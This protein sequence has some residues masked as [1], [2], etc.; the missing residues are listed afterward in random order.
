[1]RLEIDKPAMKIIENS[2][3]T[4]IVHPSSFCRLG[5]PLPYVFRSISFSWTR[6]LHR[7]LTSDC[8]VTLA[9]FLLRTLKN[10]NDILPRLRPKPYGSLTLHF[11]IKRVFNNDIPPPY[12]GNKPL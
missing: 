3:T 2:R 7:H 10:H 6:V 9:K 5:I 11:V 4:I 12:L 1:M 8:V